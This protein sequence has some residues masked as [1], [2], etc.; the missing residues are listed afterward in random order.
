MKESLRAE[1]EAYLGRYGLKPRPMPSREDR[2]AVLRETARVMYEE[3]RARD[4]PWAEDV[5]ITYEK[6]RDRHLAEN[7]HI[8]TIELEKIA[9]EIE[10][11]IRAHPEFAATFHD[12]VFVG[13]FP[14]G[15]VDCQTVKVDGGFLVLVSSGTLVMLQ[16][17]V[18]FLVRDGDADHPDSPESRQA[19]DAVAEVLATYL[20]SMDPFY[21]PKPLIG[22]MRSALSAFLSR[23]A[24]KFVVA[25]EYGHV[26]AGHLEEPGAESVPLDTKVGAIDVLRKT[27]AQEFEADDIGYRLTLGVKAYEDF[28]LGVID[29]AWEADATASVLGAATIQKCLI[30]A[31][32]VLLTVEL[33]FDKLREVERALGHAPSLF[34]THPPAKERLEKLIARRPGNS[35]RHSGFINIPFILLPSCERIMKR[36]IDRMRNPEPMATGEPTPEPAGGTA[37]QTWLDD[38]LR[39]VGAIRGG[40]YAAAALALTETFET[41]RT[42]LEPDV[43]VVRRALVR[44]ALGQTT[45]LRRAIL[46][47]HRDRRGVEDYFKGLVKSPLAVFAGLPPG[48]RPLS[49]GRLSTLLP[50]EKPNGLGLVHSVM[51]EEARQRASS[52]GEAHLL[53]AILHAWGGERE[54]S[55]ASFEA[56]LA[57]GIADPGGRI[58]RFIGLEKRALALGVQLDIQELLGAVAAK[59]LG[60]KAAARAIAELVK[61]YAGYLDVPLGPVASRIVDARLDDGGAA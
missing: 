45:E 33:I 35:P 60:D 34:D 24:Q 25:H 44:A 21:G 5:L 48:T 6:N 26:L 14:T 20:E 1:Y 50:K 27:R 9:A 16:Q 55:L 3:A 28:D 36:V 49:L 61:A 8:A 54:R 32:F 41:Q 31:P 53:R 40:D 56:A 59:A 30:A 18:T 10:A 38:I 7:R 46:D 42:M 57:A 2:E 13:E 43:D 52:S 58:A 15:S 11:T 4:D 12:N 39:C 29:A 23:A 19:A 17:V 51:D 22:G 37:R 47:R